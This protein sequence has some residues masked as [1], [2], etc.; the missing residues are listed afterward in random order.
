MSIPPTVLGSSPSLAGYSRIASIYIHAELVSVAQRNKICKLACLR[1]ESNPLPF[2]Q[3]T[4]YM[5][6]NEWREGDTYEQ[7][8]YI[9][10][11]ARTDA[12]APHLYPTS[13]A[14]RIYSAGAPAANAR[15]SP[16]S[17]TNIRRA[18]Y[19]GADEYAAQRQKKKE[20]G[21]TTRALGRI[22]SRAPR[23]E[24]NGGESEIRGKEY[25]QRGRR[26]MRKRGRA[27]YKV[28]PMGNEDSAA[29]HL[30]SGMRR[31][32]KKQEST[33]VHAKRIKAK[34]GSGGGHGIQGRQTRS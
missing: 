31:R 11:T 2:E 33:R 18:I 12:A 26:R 30:E 5:G 8:T 4:N 21:S 28:R 17:A 13:A 27:Q 24:K 16:I 10:G 23:P 15:G 19:G 32:K 9:A 3:D 7:F 1:K 29:P 22:R 14:P 34:A 6:E 20:C 25:T